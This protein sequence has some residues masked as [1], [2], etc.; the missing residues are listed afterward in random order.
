MNY[1]LII[2][3]NP[4]ETISKALIDICLD[5]EKSNSVGVKSFQQ[6]QE[7]KTM[8]VS[9]WTDEMMT[10]LGKPILTFEASNEIT[11]QSLCALSEL[12]LLIKKELTQ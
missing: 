9:E 1:R 3:G 8:R 11:Y 5:K 12:L 2:E 6:T 7:H 10:V 4:K